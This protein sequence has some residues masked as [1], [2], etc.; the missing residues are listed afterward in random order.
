MGPLHIRILGPA[1]SLGL[2][3][4]ILPTSDFI[5]DWSGLAGSAQGATT[6]EAIFQAPR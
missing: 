3:A 2:I 5:S 4:T 1:I 6:A